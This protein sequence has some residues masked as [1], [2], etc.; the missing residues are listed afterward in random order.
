MYIVNGSQLVATADH[1]P[2]QASPKSK[3][4]CLHHQLQSSHDQARQDTNGCFH[5]IDGSTGHSEIWLQAM[6]TLLHHFPADLSFY[7]CRM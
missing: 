3:V 7:S 5:L 2:V 4:L 6:K 1:T